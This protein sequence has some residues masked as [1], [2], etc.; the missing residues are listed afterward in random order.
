MGSS[1]PRDQTWVSYCRWILYHLSHQGS[2]IHFSYLYERREVCNLELETNSCMLSHFNCVQLT[3]WTVAC[4]AS[5]SMGFSRQEYWSGLPCPSPRDLPDP[6]M[7][8]CVKVKVKLLSLVWLFA[9]PWTVDYH[10]PLSVF[11]RQE[12]WSWLP[13]H[14][15]GDP[16]NPG[17][18]PWFP[19]L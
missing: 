13:F 12:Y 9:I 5:I 16:P 3:Q 15:P 10:A 18:K 8:L 14:S 4:Q 7:W 17:I 6:G 1:Q 19:A 11:S 2:P